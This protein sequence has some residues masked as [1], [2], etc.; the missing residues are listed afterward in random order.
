MKEQEHGKS[1][2]A[3]CYATFSFPAKS[4]AMGTGTSPSF[5][6]SLVFSLSLLLGFTPSPTRSFSLSTLFPSVVP[7]LIPASAVLPTLPS[8]PILVPRRLDTLPTSASP[9]ALAPR[10]VGTVLERLTLFP[11]TG[12][13]VP[14]PANWIVSGSAVTTGATPGSFNDLRRTTGFSDPRRRSTSFHPPTG[15]SCLYASASPKHA[16]PTPKAKAETKQTVP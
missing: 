1:E 16:S 2:S 6:F 12:E 15:A 8:V 3:A 11:P 13:L 7:P 14:E 5:S 9:I 4:T 10:C